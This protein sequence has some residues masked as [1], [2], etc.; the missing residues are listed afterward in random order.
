MASS[1]KF[2][3]ALLILMCLSIFLN[4]VF[5]TWILEYK[6]WLQNLQAKV[7]ELSL[8]NTVLR[9][10]L[11]VLQQ[12][13]EYYP[14]ASL[15]G[16]EE[17]IYIAGVITTE[18]GEYKGEIL[19]IY[20]RLMEGSGRVFITTSPKIGITLQDSAETAFKAAQK[21]SKFNASKVD[22]MLMVMANKTIDVVDG[23]S[24]G[25]AITVLLSL[26]FQAKE[27]QRD[28]II[29]GAIQEDGTIRKV[30]GIIEK[31]IAAAEM[32]ATTFLVPP[33]QSKSTIY[34]EK[35]TQIGPFK[36]IE[37]VPQTV[38]VQ[39]FLEEQGY[40]IKVVEV[41]SV[42]EALQYFSL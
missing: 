9:Q 34:V 12:S 40:R 20:A 41:S 32:G 6:E 42:S 23:P 5:Y 26:M 11:E 38:N 7:N 8:E 36:F 24:A 17:W 31:A 3:A 16:E 10:N 27:I 22:V 14:N 37:R 21:I 13:L 30:G 28:V 33:G 35:I 25:A 18:S 2:I 39:E 4:V 19:R 1:R 15:I 29:T